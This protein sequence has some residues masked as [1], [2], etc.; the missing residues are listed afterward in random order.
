LQNGSIVYL[1]LYRKGLLYDFDEPMVLLSELP[2]SNPFVKFC[3][4]LIQSVQMNS[5]ECFEK[6]GTNY[7]KFLQSDQFF[8]FLYQNYG[9]KYFKK[10][11][12]EAQGLL[13]MF[14]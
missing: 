9:V 11:K 13:G 5:K 3:K 4:F 6:I 7:A 1:D 10:E 2:G 8:L 12:K 14:Q